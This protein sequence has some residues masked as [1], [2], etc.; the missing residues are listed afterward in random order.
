MKLAELK[1]ALAHIENIQFQL[2]DESFV[3]AHF[4][5]TEVGVISRNF[6]DCGGKIRTENK[7][8]F[9]LWMDSHDAEHRLSPEKLL[10]I[11]RKS[12]RVLGMQDEEVEVE[13][14][15]YTIGKFGLEFDGE[16]F[17]LMNTYTDCLA[18]DKCGI[19]EAVNEAEEV[20]A[21]AEKVTACVPGN[22]CC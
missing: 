14:Q 4:H 21:S 9:Q 6:I 19:T 20:K 10:G 1:A 8:N 22:G 15:E 5:V 7:I 18:Q 17:L 3:P 16:K 11:I 2:P 12:E 13:Y